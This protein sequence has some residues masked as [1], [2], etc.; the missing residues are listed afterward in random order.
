MSFFQ[1]DLPLNQLKARW[2][3]APSQFIELQGMQVHLRDEGV[4]TDPTPI[5]LVHGTSASLHTWEGWVAALK[6]ERRVIT[7]DIPGFGLTG[8]EP[9]ENYHINRYTDFVLGL[10]DQLGVQRFVIGGN[11]LGGEIAWHVGAAAPQRV[12]QLILV[13]AA[14]FKRLPTGLPVGFAMA[15]ASVKLGL[16]WLTERVLP[17]RVIESSTRFVY[18]DARRI[19]PELNQRYFEL[20]LRPGNRKALGQRLNQHNMGQDVDQLAKLTMP[21]L[22]IWGARDRIFSVGQ[23]KGLHQAIK[24]SEFVVFDDLGHVP[25]EEDAARTVAVVRR[26]LQQSESSAANQP[27]R[28]NAA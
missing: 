19:T 16:G 28:R 9:R 12:A 18:G 11:S 10:L 22:I 1:A 15:A 17:R 27:A 14:G 20:A 3:P 21:T 26:F 8:P 6:G 2:A 5:V 23:G 13:D 24:G 4:R 7:M 25:Q